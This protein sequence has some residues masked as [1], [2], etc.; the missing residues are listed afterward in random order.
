MPSH[1]VLDSKSSYSSSY[2]QLHGNSNYKNKSP[3]NPLNNGASKSPNRKTDNLKLNQY[4][5]LNK[6]QS[7]RI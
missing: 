3:K 6:F 2:S 7:K 5:F 4:I 1:H